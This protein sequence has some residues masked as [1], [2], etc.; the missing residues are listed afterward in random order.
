MAEEYT[1]NIKINIDTNISDKIDENVKSF[2]DKLKNDLQSLNLRDVIDARQSY[3]SRD[4][5]ILSEYKS[6]VQSEIAAIEAQ[7]TAL[8][9]RQLQAFAPIM[10]SEAKKEFDPVKPFSKEFSKRQEYSQARQEMQTEFD[11]QFHSSQQ[12]TERMKRS[13]DQQRDLFL[14]YMEFVKSLKKPDVLETFSG[15]RINVRP[16]RTLQEIAAPNIFTRE[17]E[18]KLQKLANLPRDELGKE[19]LRIKHY[20][21]SVYNEINTALSKV[22]YDTHQ[23]ALRQI[24]ALKSTLEKVTSGNLAQITESIQ[25][26]L[27]SG[28]ISK[29][30]EQ[31]REAVTRA[32]EEL[33]KELGPEVVPTRRSF[34]QFQRNMVFT[35]TKP[36]FFEPAG[37]EFHDIESLS[38][39]KGIGAPI[40]G[41]YVGDP[42]ITFNEFGDAQYGITDVKALSKYLQSLMNPRGISNATKIDI[43]S[44]IQKSIDRYLDSQGISRKAETIMSYSIDRMKEIQKELLSLVEQQLRSKVGDAEASRRIELVNKNIEGLTRQIIQLPSVHKSSRGAL[45]LR[46]PERGEYLTLGKYVESRPAPNV[47][48]DKYISALMKHVKS[49]GKEPKDIP[50]QIRDLNRLTKDFWV[51]SRPREEHGVGIGQEGASE[52]ILQRVKK[53]FDMVSAFIRENRGPRATRSINAINELKTQFTQQYESALR[54]A[55]RSTQERLL[56]ENIISGDTKLPSNLEKEFRSQ[57]APLVGKGARYELLPLAVLE[58]LRKESSRIEQDVSKIP[59]DKLEAELRKAKENEAKRFGDNDYQNRAW[60]R[61]LEEF[62]TYRPVDFYSLL[63]RAATYSRTDTNELQKLRNSLSSAGR[64]GNESY[65][66]ELLTQRF[67]KVFDPIKEKVPE[68]HEAMQKHEVYGR[69]SW[70]RCWTKLIWSTC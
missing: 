19:T 28:T 33:D 18:L 8:K 67:K 20:M 27:R 4:T 66:H 46:D 13:L 26:E 36:Q 60:Q 5:S 48:E 55:L 24:D 68:E 6:K 32:Q 56:K 11:R 44:D 58:Y 37:P 52:E 10:V 51:R 47:L 34:E 49:L 38:R 41:R 31:M 21:D 2:V 7:I 25:K 40:G 54:E 63:N 64:L 69:A 15:E 42:R 35:F 22:G 53:A 17:L 45:I 61:V 1:F 65:F 50:R 3:Q 70:Y 43:G 62:S 57:L 30:V 9:N 59:Y 39:R 29:Q 16:E 12:H 14:K 23:Q